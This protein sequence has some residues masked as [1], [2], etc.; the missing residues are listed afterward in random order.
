MIIGD[1]NTTFTLSSE[2]TYLKRSVMRDLLKLAVDPDIISLAGGLPASEYLPV[3][4]FRECMDAVLLRDGSRALQYSPQWMPLRE[5]IATYMQSLG[6]PCTAEQVF[7]TNGS[8]QG[9]ALVSRLLLDSGQVAVTEA[10]VFTGIQQ[11]TA[12]RGAK[13]LTIPTDSRTG[14]DMDALEEAFQHYPKPRLAVLVPDFHNPLGVSL[15][16]EKRAQAASLAAEYGV[17]LIEDDPYSPLRFEGDPLPPIKTFDEGGYVFYLGS[18]SKM[19]APAMRLGWMVAPADL[20][21]RI[22][23]LRESIDL[24]SSTLMQRTVCE[25]L[26]R[27]LLEVHLR[28][29]NQV[30]K[31]RCAA[32]LDA[33]QTHLGDLAVWTVPTGGL[34]S[35]VTLHDNLNTWELFEEAVK[36]KVAY[37]PGAAFAV[38]G[39]FENTMRLNFSNVKP[40]AIREG[41]ARLA[42]VVRQ[43]L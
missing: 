40:D 38:H 14:A 33:L 5:W 7:I 15:T 24:E 13:V 30:N 32:L 37:I 29:M 23:V 11:V 35:W 41:V 28:R 31:E 9:L 18:F 25:F 3:D 16:E 8:Q 26:S 1:L 12:G 6:V 17:P 19:L 34:F 36:Q 2:T 20:I 21:P 39:G 43:S 42:Q 27:G 4:E 22:T 10:V